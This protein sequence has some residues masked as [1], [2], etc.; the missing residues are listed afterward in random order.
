[1]GQRINVEGRGSL[2]RA[3]GRGKGAVLYSGHLRSGFTILIG[4]AMLGYPLVPIK[5]RRDFPGHNWAE[6]LFYRRRIRLL[7][8]LGC[9]MLWTIPPN[10]LLT[11]KASAAL[12]DNKIVVILIDRWE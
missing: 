4:L 9:Q 10:P 11:A 7:E 5:D 2:A 8:K 1:M 6:R 3:V 12:R